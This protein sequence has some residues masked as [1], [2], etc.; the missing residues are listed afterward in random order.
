MTGKRTKFTSKFGF[1][2]AAAGSAVGLGNIWKFPFEVGKGGGAAFL[3]IYLLFCF[4]L[5]FP[6]LVTEIAIGRRSQK[7][8][9]MSFNTI[10][11][12]KWGFIGVLCVLC[13]IIILS[14]YNV[15][16]GWVFGYFVEILMGNFDIGNHF[17]EYVMDIKTVG[18]YSLIFMVVTAFIV[19]R[20]VTN[21]IEKASKILM[22]VLIA[23][24]LFLVGYALTLPNAMEGIKFYLIP[25]LSKLKLDVIYR[26]LGQSFFSLSIG[27]GAIM[28]YG[29][30]LK[31]T[32]NVIFAGA[33]ITITDVTIAFLA[34]LMIFPFVF[35][36]GLN[37]DG[38][39]SLIFVTMPGIFNNMGPFLGI[40][41]GSMF[42]L[43]L[44]FAAL[45][46]T[47]SLLELPVAYL[48][49]K[50]NIRR[51]LAVWI[52]ATV[53]FLAG[54]PSILAN[55][56]SDFF[57]NFINYVGSD[58]PT[59][60]MTFITDVASNT[61]LPLGGFFIAIFTVH[62]WKRKKLFRELS[63]GNPGFIRSWVAK[64][65]GFS[66]QY[67]APVILGTIF[68]ITILEIFFN[69]KLLS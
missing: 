20:G 10:G 58:K 45:T 12:P 62:I 6:I 16:A 69:V 37:A 28:T 68:I 19:S 65:V 40:F 30:Y 13:G 7:S 3:V 47:M 39:A 18:T 49:D 27:M 51:E 11:H 50:L 33:M 46:S 57:T 48:V 9:V 1:I 22:P 14:F 60:F 56:Y 23:L 53:I 21:G 38:G 63:H 24:I 43:L 32:E 8:A 17:G 36:Q 35:S 42:F 41:I 15:V 61:L 59:D 29:S 4:V 26:A 44:S 64:Y 54:L 25:D 34:G 2:A 67:I 66:L 31:K 55:G 52:S 5:C